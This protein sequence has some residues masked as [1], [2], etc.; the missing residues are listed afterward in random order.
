[1][2]YKKFSQNFIDGIIPPFHPKK[3]LYKG[4]YGQRDPLPHTYGGYRE[5]LYP[6][7]TPPPIMLYVLFHYT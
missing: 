2:F 6:H 4:G 3:P 7:T 5:V 1:M